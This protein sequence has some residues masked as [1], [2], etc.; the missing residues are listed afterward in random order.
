VSLSVLLRLVED[1]F[2]KLLRVLDFFVG[3]VFFEEKTCN[4]PDP[5]TDERGDDDVSHEELLGAIY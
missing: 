3:D 4:R 5:D 1:A 2:G